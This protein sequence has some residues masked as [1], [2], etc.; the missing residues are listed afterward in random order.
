M[1]CLLLSR[2]TVGE[3]AGEMAIADLAESVSHFTKQIRLDRGH[4]HRPPKL[5]HHDR[6]HAFSIAQGTVFA[7]RIQEPACAIW[8]G[9]G[10]GASNSTRFR[11]IC[12]TVS[13]L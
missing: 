6:A 9:K 2:G 8:V 4:I 5:P 12:R 7:T 11:A 3:R 1:R 13:N 10:W